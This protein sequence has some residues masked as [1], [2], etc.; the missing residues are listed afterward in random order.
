[1]LPYPEILRS[2]LF[3]VIRQKQLMHVPEQ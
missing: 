3:Y 1:L 2:P